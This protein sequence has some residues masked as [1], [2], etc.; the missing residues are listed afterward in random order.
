MGAD[1]REAFGSEVEV[2]PLDVCAPFSELHSASVKADAAFEGAGI[3]YFVHCAGVHIALLLKPVLAQ[4]EPSGAA[5]CA[6][7]GS[8]DFGDL[9]ASLWTGTLDLLSSLN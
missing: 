3:D 2:L 5:S 8:L 7:R 1:C 6:C 9:I 4:L